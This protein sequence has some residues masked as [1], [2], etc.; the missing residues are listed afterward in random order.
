[1]QFEKPEFGRKNPENVE[2]SFS[3]EVQAAIDVRQE[4]IDQML[5]F[6][7]VTYDDRVLIE[8]LERE[9]AELKGEGEA[10]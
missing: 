3:P 2:K 10:Q 6:G 8:K 9:I 4:R 1:M 7:D 5:A